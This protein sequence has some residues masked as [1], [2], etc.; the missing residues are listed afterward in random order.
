MV[1]LA[2]TLA[3][4]RAARG[5]WSPFVEELVAA[6]VVSSHQGVAAVDG[7]RV[8]VVYVAPGAEAGPHYRHLVALLGRALVRS[9][10]DGLLRF[11]PWTS[12]EVVARRSVADELARVG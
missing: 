10:G 8:R 7:R 6:G 3:E 4:A 12:G 1:L 11:L 2:R 9:G 5:R